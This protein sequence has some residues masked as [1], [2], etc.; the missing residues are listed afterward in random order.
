MNEVYLILIY[1]CRGPVVGR[2]LKLGDEGVCVEFETLT[3][4]IH[5]TEVNLNLAAES[6][7]CMIWCVL[8]TH[9]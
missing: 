8:S 2:L 9:L 5:R 7:I 6:G 3:Q 4:T 1:Q